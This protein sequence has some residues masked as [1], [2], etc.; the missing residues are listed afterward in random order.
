MSSSIGYIDDKNGNHVFPVTHER[1]VRD[2]EGVTLETKL[3]QKQ[4]TIPDLSTIRS[5]AAAGATAVQPAALDAKQDV[6][7]DLQTIRSGAALGSTSVQPVDIED[8]VEAE[9][10]GS[11][12]PPVNPSEFATT[13]EISQLRQDLTEKQITLSDDDLHDYALKTDGTYG[14]NAS[15]KHKIVSVTPGEKYSLYAAG[16]SGARY[17]FLASLVAPVAGG[18]IP[19][20]NGTAIVEVT[21]LT[22]AV[23]T[24]P[25]GCVALALYFGQ[26]PFPFK[27]ELYRIYSL[28]EMSE[29]LVSLEDEFGSPE[30]HIEKSDSGTFEVSAFSQ[31]LALSGL[32]I[33]SGQKIRIQITGTASRS[34]QRLYKDSWGGSQIP[35]PSDTG[36]ID[37]EYTL[38]SDI[39][40]LYFGAEV[41]ANGSLSV[42]ISYDIPAS[43]VY[44]LEE[45][46]NAIGENLEVVEQSISDIEDSIG[47]IV[48][49]T[50]TYNNVPC[51]TTPK[52]F[53]EILYYTTKGNNPTLNI[54]LTNI[55]GQYTTIRASWGSTYK[56][57][58]KVSDTNYRGTIKLDGYDKGTVVTL[59]VYVQTISAT[60]SCN[61]SIRE[62][63]NASEG[64]I[65]SGI[66]NIVNIYTTDTQL[67]IYNKM[68]SAV[69]L[70]NCDVHFENGTYNFDET[71]YDYMRNTLGFSVGFE[72]PIGGGCRYYF[73]GATLIG[74][75]NGDD[76]TV[77]ENCNV[78]GCR[79]TNGNF[80]LYDGTII[81]NDIVYCV[82]D[83]VG[84][85]TTKKSHI[86]KHIN[87]H[88]I[89]NGGDFAAGN[90]I[91]KCIGGGT[92]LNLAV[93]IDKC[94]LEKTTDNDDKNC[95]TYHGLASAPS[96]ATTAKILITNTYMTGGCG[97]YH[98]AASE[99]LETIQLIVSNCRTPAITHTDVN[100]YRAWNNTTT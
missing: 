27:P 7:S 10:I 34:T 1:A 15:Y 72:L 50:E 38:T 37:F 56:N 40:A 51:A 26:S 90:Y 82:H 16:S 61:I 94:I 12:I 46:V 39:S 41:T 78:I 20:V 80:E 100:Y 9:P 89:Y 81:A 21:T 11:I 93:V 22:S 66:R 47:T 74:E 98:K 77:H 25:S 2:S 13:E 68:A 69:E 88:Y 57:L 8:M 6:I 87:M 4:D 71:L 62:I 95:V 79:R 85:D 84:A 31:K 97:A 19:I 35:L 64:T 49:E 83:D 30:Q 73:H 28:Q 52:Y 5:G 99:E 75:Y 53:K 63:A 86:H 59:T 18:T 36:D 29:S 43:G 42:I 33:P 91:C 14:T 70:G 65:L 67:E 54:D 32:S 55:V 76:T 48:D 92:G 3:G 17:G 24:I 45:S 23:V 60:G 44:S 58:S 96:V